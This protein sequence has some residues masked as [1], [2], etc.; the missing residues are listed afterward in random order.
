MATEDSDATPPSLCDFCHH[1]T[2]VWQTERLRFGQR[3]NRGM[4]RCEVSLPIG[5]CDTCGSVHLEDGA[6]TLIEAGVLHAYIKLPLGDSSHAADRGRATGRGHTGTQGLGQEKGQ[7]GQAMK[8]AAPPCRTLTAA[9]LD[10]IAD[11]DR[12]HAAVATAL[13][14]DAGLPADQAI[15]RARETFRPGATVRAWGELASMG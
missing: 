9:R 10:R 14:H 6:E 8:S 12:D 4:V 7:S 11:L 15:T 13:Y 3:T 2:V 1:D 5:R